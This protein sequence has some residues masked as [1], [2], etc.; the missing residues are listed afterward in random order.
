MCSVACV[1]ENGCLRVLPRL[2][3]LLSTLAYSHQRSSV[4][5]GAVY[6]QQ[7]DASAVFPYDFETTTE[8]LD[9]AKQQPDKDWM[10]EAQDLFE[11]GEIKAAI[12]YCETELQLNN[13]HNAKAWYL[14][15]KC[16]AEQ[17]ED[18]KA[19]ACLERSVEM[20]PYSPPA[21]LALGVSHV[22]ELNHG[23]ALLY[24]QNWMTHNPKYAGLDI[25]DATNDLYGDSSTTKK[26]TAFEEAQRLLLTAMEHDPTDAQVHEALGVV[27]NVSRDYDAAISSFQ[28]ALELSSSQQSYSLWNKLGAT[29]ANANR[30][31]EAL[32]HYHSSLLNRPKYARAWLN[33][34][35]SHSNLKNYDEAA[36]CYLQTLSLNPS[37]RHCW[38]YLRIALTCSE[39]WDLIPLAAKQDLEAFAQHYDFVQY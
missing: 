10:K 8:V 11:R 9:A 26:E 23:R 38:S 20:D 5:L 12:E 6:Q 32:P 4:N 24:L 2:F 18:S 29:L 17:D 19:I 30:S 14:L 7:E 35:I 34:A 31:D 37:A 25:P 21:L 16:H 3:S 22:N 36:R 33:M 1:R 28:K 39:K 27:Y 13:E 15:G